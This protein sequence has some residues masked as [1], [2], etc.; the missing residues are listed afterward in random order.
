MS[1]WYFVADKSPLPPARN[2][3][4]DEFLFKVCQR[5]S[6]GFFRIYSWN[7]P[8]FSIG[9][10]QKISKAINIEYI[11]ENDLGLVRRITGGKT[12]LHDDEITYSIISSEEKFFQDN[13]L[14]KSYSLI[15]NIILKTFRRTGINAYLS[16]RSDRILSKSSN[17]CFSFPTPNEIEVE[18]KKILGSAQKTDKNALL[19]HGSIPISMNYNTYASGTGFNENLIKRNMTSISELSSIKP[20]MVI[21]NFLISL[22]EFVEK[23]L[24]EYNYSKS[25]LNEINS[26]EKKYES[27]KW[28]LSI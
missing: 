10:H 17:P 5:E 11:R 9:V 28:N 4:I 6:A 22:E 14:F 8:S 24:I 26:L 18:G 1:N 13:D 2:M 3:A 27:E 23:E 12:V 7:K 15:S 16:E 20:D 19:Q 25:D 21:K